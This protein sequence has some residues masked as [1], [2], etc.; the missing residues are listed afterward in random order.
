MTAGVA[1]KICIS[2]QRRRNSFKCCNCKEGL[3]LAKMIAFLYIR[4]LAVS[5]SNSCLTLNC[6]NF[7]LVVF[8]LFWA[9]IGSPF[10][11]RKRFLRS[12]SSKAISEVSL[13]NSIS[14]CVFTVS[15]SFSLIPRPCFLQPQFGIFSTVIIDKPTT[16]LKSP[17]QTMSS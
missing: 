1:S 17:L 11:D 4:P 8:Q 7:F 10:H 16:P 13:V 15:V 9:S 3:W 6:P 14:R 5:Q 12:C 2:G